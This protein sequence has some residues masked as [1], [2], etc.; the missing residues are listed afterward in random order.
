MNAI[1]LDLAEELIPFSSVALSGKPRL[2]LISHAWGGGIDRHI[3]DLVSLVGADADVLL[4]RGLGRGGVA[5]QWY[6]QGKATRA[7]RVGGFDASTLDQWWRALQTIGFSRIHLHHAQGW[8]ASVISLIER[9]GL[10]LDVTLHDYLSICPQYNLSDELGRYC[11]EPDDDGCTACLKNRPSLW[12]IGIEEWRAR[13]GS[14][15]KFADRII[16]PSSDVATRVKRYFPDLALIVQPH[17]EK[18]SVHVPRSVKVV[19]LGALSPVKG[20]RVLERVSLRAKKSAPEITFRLIGHSAEALPEGVSATGS[21][22]DSMLARIIADERPDLIWFPAQIPETYSYT[23]TQAMGSGVPIVASDLGALRERLIGREHDVLLSFDAS[24]DA[25]IEVFLKVDLAA[26]VGKQSRNYLPAETGSN[27]GYYRA[28]YLAPIGKR[29]E[30]D[31]PNSR[32]LNQLV[33]AAPPAPSEPARPISDVFRVGVFGGH[34]DSVKVV[35]KLLAEL[36]PGE[37]H[38]TGRRQTIALLNAIEQKDAEIKQKNTLIIEKNVAIVEAN[39]AL[40]ELEEIKQTAQ[41]NL[42]LSQKN[43]AALQRDASAAARHIDHLET[44]RQKILNSSSW[45]LTRP[46]RVVR[47]LAASLPLLAKRALHLARHSPDARSRLMRLYRRGG[48]TA[49]IER[50]RREISESQQ[51]VVNENIDPVIADLLSIQ[52]I[53]PLLVASS[54][55]P[56]VSIVIPVYGQHVTTFA[57]LSSIALHPPSQSYEI[58]VTDDCS[59]EPAASA[60]AQ[61]RG[62]RFVR[63]SRNLGF[64]GNVNA[65]VA[66]ARGRLLV[67]LNNDTVVTA[68]AIDALVRTF[69][70][71]TNVGL[72]GAKLIN[73]DGTLQEAG[74]IIWRDGSGWNW[75]RNQDRHD[76][77]F[78]FVRD[79]DY[80]SGAA[81]ATPSELFAALGGFDSHYAPAYYEDTDLAF[82]IRERGLRV[83]YQP[84]AEILHIE[85]VSHGRDETSGIKAYQALN[86]KKFFERWESVLA[87]HRVNGE[88]PELESHRTT[89]LNILIVEAC[90]ITPDQDSGSVRM[91]NLIRILKAEGHHVTFV[92]DNLEGTRK[93]AR[94]MEAIGAEVLHGSWAG[95]VHTVLRT[96]GHTL[97]AIVFCRHYIASEYIDT[98]RLHAPK[99][100]IIFDTVDLHFVREQREATLHANAVMLKAAQATREKEIAIIE[101]SDVTVV[102]SEFEKNLL[103][104]ILPS[105]RVAI[106]SN[107]HAPAAKPKAYES[108]AGLLFVGGFR[109]P[110]NVD[111]IKWYASEVMPLLSSLLPGVVT[112]VVGSNMTEEIQ[113]LHSD[114]LQILGHI[115]NIEPL[116]NSARVSIAPL[117]YGAGVKGK[118]NEA[119]NHGIP[120]VATA[121]AVEGMHLVFGEEVMVAESA[122]EFALAIKRVYNDPVLWSKLSHAGLK[123]VENFF[124]MGSAIAGVR[125]VF[126]EDDR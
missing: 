88:A 81:L 109:H 122:Q 117:R 107:I 24:E 67:I 2:L 5:L 124:S 13:F 87:T 52:T 62:V 78:N 74:G 118:V 61:I 97:D 15:L 95:N 93:Y 14:L 121:C 65:G 113:I 53:K 56:V 106:I 91:L 114:S 9:L 72:V 76:P 37:T 19:I 70:E 16:V 29:A 32:L 20:L 60:L 125:E 45:K 82:R 33:E 99:A 120:V 28:M 71:H 42:A 59:P 49:V 34:R 102:V 66:H 6:V 105:A 86:A 63:N 31:A 98:V 94:Q 96:R 69:D 111:A 112:H 90:M 22:D 80:C 51:L 68:D 39:H 3:H 18:G 57:C 10:P 123:N 11:G 26:N 116:L 38:V 58:I 92:A 73:R 23:L 103:R 12:G 126:G 110:P 119:M 64:I 30:V 108:R 36:P 84:R 27:V 104:E 47:R 50:A 21:Y 43:T 75:G 85:G 54:D 8:T 1:A 89:R 79:A 77:R 48:A 25:W 83:L 35:E 4:L 55:T 101:K 115:E 41:D 100:R 46:L 44:E 17:P 7:E 40:A